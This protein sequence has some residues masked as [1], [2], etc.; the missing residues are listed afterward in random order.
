M[1][2]S[3]WI[4]FT[5]FVKKCLRENKCVFPS[6]DSLGIDVTNLAG[7]WFPNTTDWEKSFMIPNFWCWVFVRF[8]LC[9]RIECYGHVPSDQDGARYKT[10]PSHSRTRNQHHA[11]QPIFSP[12]TYY[13][14]WIHHEG[15]Y[16]LALQKEKGKAEFSLFRG[17]SLS[18]WVNVV[19]RVMRLD[20]RAIFKHSRTHEKPV[21]S[22][23][24]DGMLFSC[25]C[26]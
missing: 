5:L 7:G 12:S 1:L 23:S 10:D 21:F 9:S 20:S 26:N 15:K 8:S 16:V 3:C 17:K 19:S 14:F 6:L 4:T 2:F 11:L 24:S 22:A 25:I 13:L 18:D